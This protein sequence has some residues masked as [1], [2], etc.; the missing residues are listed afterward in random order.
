MVSPE[1]MSCFYKIVHLM[2][3]RKTPVLTNKLIKV[4]YLF[5]IENVFFHLLIGFL[6][7]NAIFDLSCFSLH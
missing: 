5:K 3:F 6:M 1:V 7:R 4:N 2:Q